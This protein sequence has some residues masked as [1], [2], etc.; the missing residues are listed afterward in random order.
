MQIFASWYLDPVTFE[1][2]PDVVVT[3]EDGRVTDVQP[4]SATDVEPLRSF[5]GGVV[6]PGFVN[7]HAHLDLTHLRGSLPAG[8]AFYEWV[9]GVVAGRS[10]PDDMIQDGIRFGVNRMLSTGTTSVLDISVAG[11]SAKHL[12]DAGV[13]GIAAL[14]VLAMDPSDANPWMEKIDGVIRD[15]FE[16]DARRLGDDVDQDAPKGLRNVDFGYS[17]HAPYSTSLDLYQHTVGRAFGESRVWTTHVSETREEIEFMQSGT[18]ALADLLGGMGFDLSVFKAPGMTPIEWVFDSVSPW[19][20]PDENPQG[21][22]VHVNYPV[23]DDWARLAE[24]RPSVAYCPRSHRWFDHE[25]WPV[26]QH[27]EAGV[28]LCLGTD[29]WASNH[30]LD[31][32][33]EIRCAARQLT[34]VPMTTWFRAATM[35]GRKALGLAD[36][37]ADLAVWQMPEG[38][39]DDLESLLTRL[40]DD[41]TRLMA[42]IVRGDL[43]ARGV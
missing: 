22:L 4:G 29:S 16:L 25:P 9:P 37:V 20:K 23:G 28:N 36:D 1:L 41:P 34:H 35:N 26:D 18:G 6:F 30:D 39:G 43:I 40:V 38:E 2:R 33:G 10:M 31:M 8:V 19:L 5:E 13:S 27:L 3:L 12:S 14:E 24:V 15:L 21:V 17:P 32:W 11:D 42:A 7:A